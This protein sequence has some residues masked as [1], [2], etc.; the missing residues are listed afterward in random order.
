[1]ALLGRETEM[2]NNGYIIP[3]DIIVSQKGTWKKI[4][5]SFSVVRN[6]QLCQALSIQIPKGS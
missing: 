5:F 6:S 2:L 1:M 4:C 3:L